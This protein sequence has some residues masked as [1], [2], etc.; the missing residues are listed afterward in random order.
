MA[1]P[2]RA[3]HRPFVRDGPRTYG[4]AAAA[5]AAP[6][7][8]RRT[9]RSGQTAMPLDSAAAIPATADEDALDP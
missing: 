4:R 7:I 8:A 1:A 5:P 9:P 6:H 3:S 2:R